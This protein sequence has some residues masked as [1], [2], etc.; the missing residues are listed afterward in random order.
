LLHAASYLDPATLSAEAK[1]CGGGLPGRVTSA[2]TR[3]TY[4]IALLCWGAW[5]ALRYGR[6]LTARPSMPAVIQFPDPVN[7]LTATIRW[8]LGLLFEFSR[9]RVSHL[10]NRRLRQVRCKPGVRPRLGCDGQP[11][12]ALAH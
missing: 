10:I 2:K 9:H 1:T 11:P 12:L 3:R 5:Y 6:V 4:Q 7:I 8:Q